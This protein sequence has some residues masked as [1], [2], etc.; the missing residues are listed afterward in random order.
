MKLGQLPKITLDLKEYIW[1]KLK[2][3]KPNVTIKQIS[4]PSVTTM[5]ETHSELYTSTIE[6]DN[7]MAII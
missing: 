2:P 3:K 1:Q 7:H 4:K 5:V 6:V